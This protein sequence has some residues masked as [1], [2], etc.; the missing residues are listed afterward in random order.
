MALH[1]VVERRDGGGDAHLGRRAPVQRQRPWQGRHREARA[2]EGRVLLHV[3][4]RRPLQDRHLLP[5]EG[6]QAGVRQALRVPQP[7]RPRHGQDHVQ[8]QRLR[9]HVEPHGE[10]VPGKGDDRRRRHGQELLRGVEADIPVWRREDGRQRAPQQGGAHPRRGVEPQRQGVCRSLRLHPRQGHPLRHEVQAR[11][12]LRHRLPQHGP[13]GAPRPVPGPG[14][15]RKHLRKHGVLGQQPQ[16]AALCREGPRVDQLRV[17]PVLALLPHRHPLPPPA[18]RQR[19]QGVE[20]RR[21]PGAHAGEQRR[22]VPSDVEADCRGGLP[23]SP[24]QPGRGPERVVVGLAGWR[25]GGGEGSVR[26]SPPEG[27]GGRDPQDALAPRVRGGQEG[28]RR[29]AGPRVPAAP[30]R[31][32]GGGRE[33][34]KGR[35]EEE[36]GKGKGREGEAGAGAAGG[37]AEGPGGGGGGRPRGEARRGG[38]GAQGGGAQGVQVGG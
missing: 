24:L 1:Q 37:D 7:R 31:G 18:R 2:R 8:G 32:L 10:R 29:G 27:E 13:L 12:R 30:P 33:A 3:A 14:G 15:V 17:V 35:A 20:V 34:V 28:G 22:D 25:Q 23:R 21:P 5:R 19:L 16:E 9:V 26:A 36:E 11:L 38:G 4:R 6:R